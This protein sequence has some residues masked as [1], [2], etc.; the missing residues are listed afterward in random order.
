M[1]KY[2]NIDYTQ[3]P[4][5]YWDD[6]D[7]LSALLRNVKGTHRRQM[8]T[9]YWRQGRV[10]ELDEELL[11]D[12][13]SSESRE[14]LSRIHPSFMGGEYLPDYAP[15]EVE[16]ARIQLA[17]TL[18]DVISLRAARDPQGIRYRV[19]DEYEA[20][21]SL[22]FETSRQPLT[23]KRLIRFIERTG[24]PDL[25]G[26]LAFAYNEMNTESCTR[27]QLRHFTT[28]SSPIYPQLGQHF[29]RCFE[30]WVKR[31]R[32]IARYRRVA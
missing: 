26:G 14:R 10:T 22:P 8:I 2:P 24:V 5:S 17:S 20:E 31:D 1:K 9:D 6:Q 3:R 16:I 4:H 27:A 12:T 25:P 18:S 13:L 21:F 30:A 29:D 28:L 11:K 23:L 7:V 32:P 19:V 15:T